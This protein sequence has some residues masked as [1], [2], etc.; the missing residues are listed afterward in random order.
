MGSLTTHL[1]SNIE[2]KT[3]SKRPK[4]PT[5]L[6]IQNVNLPEKRN[7]KMQKRETCFCPGLSL[8]PM[9]SSFLKIEVKSLFYSLFQCWWK[10]GCIYLLCCEDRWVYVLVP[11]DLIPR[12]IFHILGITDDALA[13]GYVIA[14]A[15]CKITPQIEQK[16]AM[17]L[18]KWFGYEI[19]SR[20][21]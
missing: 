6:P 8:F 14:K 7:S 15:K 10:D 3:V 16:V 12:R 9:D 4:L 13:L 18:D 2:K 19:S 5:W 11:G 1:L 20:P 17:Q 21:C